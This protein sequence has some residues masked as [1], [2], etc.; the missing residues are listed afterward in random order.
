MNFDVYYTL[1]A[2]VMMKKKL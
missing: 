2:T 1:I